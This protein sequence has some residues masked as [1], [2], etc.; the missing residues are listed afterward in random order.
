MVDDSDDMRLVMA[1]QLRASGYEVIEARDGREAVELAREHRPALIFMDI[2][3]PGMGGLAATRLLREIDG[4]SDIRIAAFSAF[5][6]GDNRQL[7]L[8]AGCNA[9]FNKTENINRLPGIAAHF[10]SAS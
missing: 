3:M 7:A 6:S 5:G 1:M 4:L 10:L 2:Y 9:Y 8:D